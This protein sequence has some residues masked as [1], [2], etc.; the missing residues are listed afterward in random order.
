M[1]Y[2]IIEMLYATRKPDTVHKLTLNPKLALT[3]YVNLF[4]IIQK[5]RY[6]L[7][8]TEHLL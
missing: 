1:K 5:C 8:Q 3:L 6:V 4:Y 7:L 2:N